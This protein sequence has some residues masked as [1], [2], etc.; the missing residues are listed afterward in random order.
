M[1]FWWSQKVRLNTVG[2]STVGA[3]RGFCRGRTGV[4]STRGACNRR[5][6][7][8]QLFSLVVWKSQYW[9]RS[10]TK[11]RI[12][13]IK[14]CR[15]RCF[16]LYG[17]VRNT[18]KFIHYWPRSVNMQRIGMSLHARITSSNLGSTHCVNDKVIATRLYSATSR[19]GPVPWNSP[20]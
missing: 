16:D 18:A 19:R 20:P 5:S 7:Q 1:T 14:N 9:A 13:E 12:S 11:W 17:E 3:G 8:N 10:V 15:F 2:P 4:V 6:I